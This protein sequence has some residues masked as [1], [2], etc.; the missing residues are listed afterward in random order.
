MAPEPQDY[1]PALLEELQR[2]PPQDALE[3]LS[4]AADEHPRDPRPLVL[5]AGQQMH[6]GHVDRAEG[7]YILAL[8]RAPDFALARFQ[9][10]L[11]Q[12]TSARPVAAVATW[13][14]LEAL[15]ET[16]PLVLF[17]RGLE[18]LAQDRFAE[19]QE[20]LLSG[21]AANKANEPLNKDMHKVIDRMKEM[22]LLSG[23][24][25]AASAA[26]AGSSAEPGHVLISG[27]KPR[28]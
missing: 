27:Y 23:T 20:L 17:K 1:M 24:A 7:A 12:F 4:R 15:P 11:L 19:A 25:P 10:G 13:A 18:S 28:S 21:I 14:P 5:L 3:L 22:G 8:Q 6:L 9:L 26:P 2:V 16:E